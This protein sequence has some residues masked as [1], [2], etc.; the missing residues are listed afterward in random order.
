MFV[1]IGFIEFICNW[2]ILTFFYDL[3]GKQFKGK[4]LIF[5]R[6][7]ICGYY[8][9]KDYIS[10]KNLCLF[11]VVKLGFME[12]R[13]KIQTFWSIDFGIDHFQIWVSDQIWDMCQVLLLP[14]VDSIG[15]KLFKMQKKSIFLRN[16]KILVT[17]SRLYIGRTVWP[18][19]C[20]IEQTFAL[21]VYRYRYS[22][23]QTV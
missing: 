11:L 2:G 8:T 18:S 4:F 6:S 20:H 14:I 21:Y 16:Q 9:L 15:F 13:L 19:S 7:K 3:K 22:T 1:D 17:F 12:W 5:Y 23:V 10:F